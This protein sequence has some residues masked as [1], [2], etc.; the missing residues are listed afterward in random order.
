MI[1]VVTWLWMDD[2]TY[3]KKYAERHVNTLFR[4]IKRHYRQ[5]FRFI[6]IADP[7]GLEPEVFDNGVELLIRPNP[8]PQLKNPYGEG[9]P[10][11]YRRL[12]LFGQDLTDLLTTRWKAYRAFEPDERII[13]MDLDVVVTGDLTPIFER[14]EDF[15]IWRSFARQTQYNGS[16]WS[17]KPHAR[18]KVWTEFIKDPERARERARGA[19]YYGS[20]QAW[21]N[22]ILGP[23]ERCYGE[24]DGI[25]S[26]RRHLKK[27]PLPSD[28][29][30]V[31]F[32]GLYA[33]W[34]P[35]VQ[36]KHPWIKEHY[37]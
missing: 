3:Q 13:S 10:T 31:F 23:K 7:Y 4:M 29:K 32:E 35:E 12:E 9:T 27:S 28:A 26:F 8:V 5:P 24:H 19:G 22:Y 36:E 34:D 15:T 25:Y 1:T 30:I 20:D 11:C 14:P 6:C 37:Q 33:P 21:M 17:M 18:P 2:K 16:L